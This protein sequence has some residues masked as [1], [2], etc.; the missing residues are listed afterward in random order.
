MARYMLLFS[1]SLIS[2]LCCCGEDSTSSNDDTTDGDQPSV[3]GDEAT[4]GDATV[5]G[6][7]D[8]VSDFDSDGD[9]EDGDTEQDQEVLRC[10]LENDLG[11]GEHSITIEH[12]EMERR[13]LVYIPESYDDTKPTPLIL[14]LHGFTSEAW[15]Q[16]LFSKMNETADEKGFIVAY[17][18]GYEY[19]WNSG[20]YCCG[21]AVEENIDDVGFLKAVIA[22]IDDRLCVD[23]KRVYATGMSNGGFMS[24]RLAC[25]A[26]D[27]FAAVAPVAGALAY[28]NC[29]PSRP[30]PIIAYNG[31]QDQTVSIESGRASIEQWLTLNNCTDETSI[32]QFGTSTCTTHTQC[33]DGVTI[34]FC[35]MDPMGHCWPGGSESL[36]VLSGNA[37]F[38]ED[39]DANTHMYE[40]FLQY[41]LP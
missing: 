3:D 17:P 35:E 23:R 9:S 30:M 12:N 4:D 32:L 41:T 40:F 15:Q 10:P 2:L 26:G 8:T 20:H 18:D 7:S 38:N 34:S 29:N 27:V 31:V 37:P 25:D 16:V 39:I 21:E 1:L 11:A 24:F 33:D 36:C 19:S 13:Y 28:D 22:D 5:D 6:D 14:N